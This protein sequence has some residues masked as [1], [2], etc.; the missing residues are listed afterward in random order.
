M[1]WAIGIGVFILV[2]IIGNM[3]GNNGSDPAPA[4]RPSPIVTNTPAPAPTRTPR[5]TPPPQPPPQQVWNASGYWIDQYGNRFDVRHDGLNFFA[6]GMVSGILTEITGT[7]T[8]RG[9]QFV[10][11]FAT[12]GQLAGT[13]QVYPDGNNNPHMRFQLS[14]GTGGDFKIN[15]T[16]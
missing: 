8:T 13:G 7:L 2:G 16:N 4:P 5:P 3:T 12:G 9:A 1:K 10:I 6:R 14:D 11:R 15:H